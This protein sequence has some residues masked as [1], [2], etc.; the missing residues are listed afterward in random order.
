MLITYHIIYEDMLQ[1]NVFENAFLV[2]GCYIDS[3]TLSLSISKSILMKK[4]ELADLKS[5]F[6]YDNTLIF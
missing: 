5:P 1:R 6:Q 2:S 3:Q 4:I